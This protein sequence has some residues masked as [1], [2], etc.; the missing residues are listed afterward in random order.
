MPALFGCDVTRN[1]STW[2]CTAGG[3]AKKLCI[4]LFQ[5]GVS[6]LPFTFDTSWVVSLNLA[7]NNNGRESVLLRVVFKFFSLKTLFEGTKQTDT[8]QF[9]DPLF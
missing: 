4:P 3:Q 1:Q 7:L 5:V 2:F 9:G 6:C 8:T